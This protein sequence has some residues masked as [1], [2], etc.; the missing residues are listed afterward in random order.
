MRTTAIIILLLFI[1]CVEIP[2]EPVET[3]LNKPISSS[4]Y[5]LSGKWEFSYPHPFY[6][7]AEGCSIHFTFD[8][9]TIS[10][11][12]RFF[13]WKS[14][15]NPANVSFFQ[16]VPN[17]PYVEDWGTWIWKSDSFI[18]RNVTSNGL[19]LRLSG[20]LTYEN[21]RGYSLY[22]LR[23]HIKLYRENKDSLWK[24]YGSMDLEKRKGRVF[25]SGEQLAEYGYRI[26]EKDK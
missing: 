6:N 16:C 2:V 21:D 22:S 19:R 3:Q 9:L 18:D 12:G 14:S 24:F 8:S 25:F 15:G 7:Y 23:Y 5:G 17:L 4:R 13:E 26:K 11:N 10:A 1:G 20:T